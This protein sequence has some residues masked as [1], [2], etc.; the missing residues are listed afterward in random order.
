MT[1]SCR[2]IS[3]S[4]KSCVC[5]A[6]GSWC[7][8]HAEDSS[9]LTESHGSHQRMQQGTLTRHMLQEVAASHVHAQLHWAS[10]STLSG[11]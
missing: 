10:R 4:G 3:N 6:D 9:S 7:L 2:Q 8:D 11:S 1:R 5:P